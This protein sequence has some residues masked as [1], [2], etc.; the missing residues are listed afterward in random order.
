LCER[1]R[2]QRDL[3]ASADAGWSSCDGPP[4]G[5]GW[6][7]IGRLQVAL[8]ID[9]PRCEA[10]DYAILA[11]QGTGQELR[12]C[13]PR[14]RWTLTAAAPRDSPSCVHGGPSATPARRSSTPS[15]TMKPACEAVV[16]VVRMNET[17]ACSHH[18]PG[19]VHGPGMPTGRS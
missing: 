19:H 10:I 17:A 7:T 9:D 12:P 2:H 1:S 8:R 13:W 11:V 5:G 6:R 4:R 15:G 3:P 14:R 18:A 16:L